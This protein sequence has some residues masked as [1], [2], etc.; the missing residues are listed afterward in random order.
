MKKL[1]KGSRWILVR[2]RAELSPKETA[3]L[4]NIL[5]TCPDLRA[6][7][8]LKEEFRTIFEK[9]HCREKAARFLDAWVL[10]AKRTGN[11]YL[12]KFVATFKNWRKEILNYGKCQASCRLNVKKLS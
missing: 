2:N 3:H 11:K 8:L 6:L 9:I 10:K 12:L 1:L 5:K 4:D 7:Y